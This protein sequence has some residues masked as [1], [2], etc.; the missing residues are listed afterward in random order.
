MAAFCEGGDEPI[1]RASHLRWKAVRQMTAY[2]KPLLS[3]PTATASAR[4]AD[5][6]RRVASIYDHYLDFNR[7]SQT[8][9]H[10]HV[11]ACLS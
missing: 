11:V 6:F 9:R 3:K 2:G 1:T 8:N 7:S 10:V 5:V 4:P